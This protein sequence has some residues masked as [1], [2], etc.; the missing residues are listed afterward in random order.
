Q[1]GGPLIDI[2]VHM[3]EMA[4]YLMGRPRPVAA[5]ASTYTYLGDKPSDIES[6]WA[7]W[8]YETYTV[9]DLATGYIRFE[10]GACMAVESSFAAHIEGTIMN[11][12]VMGDKGGCTYS[13]PQI[14]KDEAGTMV[15]VEPAYVGNY[16]AFDRKM[17]N[18][19]AYLRGEEETKCP[20]EDGLVLQKMLDGLY[21]SAG[22]GQ[23]VEID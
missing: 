6:R 13:P 23:E 5:S 11:V 10:N 14:F 16:N 21:K 9:E 17:E 18:W 12:Q 20:A 19:V 8:D 7:G 4:H 1:G 2:G 15:N 22:A 3:M